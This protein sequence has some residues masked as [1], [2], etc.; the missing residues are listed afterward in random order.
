MDPVAAVYCENQVSEHPDVGAAYMLCKVSG[1]PIRGPVVCAEYRCP[2]RPIRRRSTIDVRPL[3]TADRMHARVLYLILSVN[4]R[5]TP[6]T[7]SGYFEAFDML[8]S[9]DDNACSS[10]PQRCVP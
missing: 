5:A 4:M 2:E 8:S 9:I 7:A 3:S 10:A 6:R 1:Y